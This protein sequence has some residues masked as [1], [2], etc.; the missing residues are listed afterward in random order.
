MRIS[1]NWLKE[2]IDIKVKPQK[3]A[4]DLTLFGHEVE[5]IEKAG[6]DYILDFEI[7]PN[8]G[9]CLSIIGMAREAVA[10]YDK[11]F[12]IKN[13]KL[14]ISES[15]INKNIKVNISDSSICSCFSARII[16]NIKVGK[17]PKWLI[18]RLKSYGFRSLNN[19]VDITNYAMIETGQPL[20]AFDY[21]KIHSGIMN[22]K[23]AASGESMITLDGQEQKLD[24]NAIVIDDGKKIFDLAGIMG[25]FNSEV[26][27]KTK[28][29]VLQ[30]AIFDPILI[31]R[32]S[33]RLNHQTDASYRFERSVDYE[34]SVRGVNKAAKLIKQSCPKCKI[35]K[36]ID[37]KSE[38]RKKKKIKINIAKINK[39]LGTNLDQKQIIDYLHR[40]EFKTNQLI[41]EVPSYREFDVTI[42]QDIAEEV[43]RMY[44]YNN[45]DRS[46]F[47]K[48]EH[49]ESEKFI[50][51]KHIKD[52]LCK[53]GFTECYSYSFT[54]EKLIKMLNYKLSDCQEVINSISPENKYLRLSIELSL[55]TAAAKNPWVPEINIFEIGKVFHT[56]GLTQK[57][58]RTNAEEKWQLGILT[59]NK[60]ANNIKSILNQLNISTDIISADQ[61]IL[62]YLKIRK[63]VKYI[64]IDL[65]KIKISAKDYLTKISNQKYKKVSEFPPTVRD[66]AFIVDK[67]IDANQIQTQI[68]HLDSH[69]LLVDLFDEFTSDKFGKNKKN[70]AYHIWLQNLK[71]PM[72]AREVD[73]I[74][75][76]IIN[77][78]EKKYQAKLRG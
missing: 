37:I 67:K 60:K 40:L 57:N 51:K 14:K 11:K 72:N 23:Q 68:S 6:D 56:H 45:L 5:S 73:K 27:K 52:I 22:I 9:D 49:K 44:G 17:S 75:K 28:T 61:K 7:T 47:K 16:D 54:D 64:V 74:T 53:N 12:K 59:T 41:V 32:T 29:I 3:L 58:S 50:L 71:K 13:L 62:D 15:Q 30:G 38:K 19:I 39:L 4:E 35:G 26:D 55:L 34:G 20:H 76:E 43:A 48:T 69:V 2:F 10:L 33:K 18:D 21:N 25:G 77:K 36:L 31:R 1:Y 70:I 42:W 78:I 24:K 66:L 65:N 63:K 46:L 8:R